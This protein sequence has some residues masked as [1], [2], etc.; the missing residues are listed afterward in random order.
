MAIGLQIADGEFK[1]IVK[2]NTKAGRMYRVDRTQTSTGWEN[3]DVDITDTAMFVA[4]MPQMKVGWLYFAPTGGPQRTM[5]P[6]GERIPARPADE[7]K[8]GIELTVLLHRNCSGENGA[9]R[10]FI[11]NATSVLKV[12]DKLHDD[13]LSAAESRQGK[14]PVVKLNGVK[15]EKT[16]H[17]TNYV[18][19]FEIVG[20]TD[21]PASLPVTGG[22]ATQAASVTAPVVSS[23]PPAPV[24]PPPVP[25][26]ASADAYDFG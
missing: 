24:S 15:A 8:Q 20:W 4:D 13:Y 10:E 14:L 22:A 17:G 16:K 19:N 25:Q 26:P 11:H 5:V 7:Y 18:P 3:N 9:P 23:P 21:R 12:I 2:Y 1:P 6:L